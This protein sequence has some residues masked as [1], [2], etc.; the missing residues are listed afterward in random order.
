MKN[1]SI[2]NIF[3]FDV[4]ETKFQEIS[5]FINKLEKD[6]LIDENEQS[7]LLTGGNG[8]VV[9]TNVDCI[10]FFCSNDNCL[11]GDCTDVFC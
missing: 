6:N 7:I 11:N 10:N 8:P 9:K 3:N 1:K 5:Q 2:I 4:M